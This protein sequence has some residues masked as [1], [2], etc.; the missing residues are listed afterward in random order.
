MLFAHMCGKLE[1]I[2]L[3]MDSTEDNKFVIDIKPEVK[4][5]G[6]CENEEDAEQNYVFWSYQSCNDVEGVKEEDVNDDLISEQDVDEAQGCM[7]DVMIDNNSV[8]LKTEIGNASNNKVDDVKSTDHMHDTITNNDL[9]KR[10]HTCST[11]QKGFT[12]SGSLNTHMLIHIGEKPHASEVCQREFTDM[13][14]LKSNIERHTRKKP[15]SCNMCKEGFTQASS[16]TIRNPHVCRVCNKGC[17][18]ASNLKSHMLANTREKPHVCKLCQKGF[19]HASTLKN[20]MLTHTGENQ[21]V[22][23]SSLK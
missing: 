14:T 1:K 17:P 18:Q 9:S 7:S 22:C 16:L 15:Y 12:Q 4:T 3:I 13:S 23:A 6:Y 20:H 5:E 11:R 21:H 19:T 10:P 2:Y 8:D